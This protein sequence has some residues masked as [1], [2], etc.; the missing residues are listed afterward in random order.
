M[1]YLKTIPAILISGLI[2]SGCSSKTKNAAATAADAATATE[3]AA[4]PVKVMHS[5][6]NKNCQNN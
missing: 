1:K 3:K 5:G 2:L 4:I 6:K